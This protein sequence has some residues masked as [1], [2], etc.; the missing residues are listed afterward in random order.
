VLGVISAN[1]FFA[2]D[3]QKPCGLTDDEIK[4]TIVGLG[5]PGINILEFPQPIPSNAPDLETTRGV[6]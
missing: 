3:E 2:A 1:L 6:V 4:G 5:V